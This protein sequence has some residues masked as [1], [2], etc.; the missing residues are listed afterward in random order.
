MP[1]RES[2]QIEICGRAYTIASDEWQPLYIKKL[3]EMLNS[4]ISSVEQ[5]TGTVDSYKLMMLA[6]LRIIDKKLK[7]S[8]SKAGSSQAIEEE[9]K[10]LNNRIAAV[11]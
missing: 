5:E 9:I 1:E 6:A 10:N 2:T 4:E 8:E 7:L 11:V 3:G